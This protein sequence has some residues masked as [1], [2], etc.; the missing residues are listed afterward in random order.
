MEHE[1]R[2]RAYQINLPRKAK[3]FNNGVDSSKINA[4]RKSAAEEQ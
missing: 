4:L 3:T 2:M 1:D